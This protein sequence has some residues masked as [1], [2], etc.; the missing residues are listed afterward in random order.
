MSSQSKAERLM[1]RRGHDF[2][3]IWLTIWINESSAETVLIKV[4]NDED[5]G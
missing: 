5:S 1:T 2:R 4:L 3:M